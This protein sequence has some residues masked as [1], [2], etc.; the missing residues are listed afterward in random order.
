MIKT[1]IIIKKF[2][3]FVKNRVERI[4]C[5]INPVEDARSIGVTIGEGTRFYGT[6]PKMFSTEPWIIKIGENCNITADVLFE[7]HDAA[8]LSVEK[9]C[10]RWVIVGDIVVG[11]NVY[12][13]T[14]TTI[15][16][17]VHI[18]DNTIIGAGS[19]V[20][21][22]IPSNVVA[23]GVPCR[24]IRSRDEYIQKVLDIKAG[25]NLRYYSDL[26]YL[27]SLDPRGSKNE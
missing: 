11:N 14:R 7:T 10:G 8:T 4:Y 3:K 17:G 25:K 6:S 12:I 26:D 20:T 9:E 16:P 22:D 1:I 5:H 13:G 15:L 24:V 21:K 23:A 27:H 18:G 2:K 19:V